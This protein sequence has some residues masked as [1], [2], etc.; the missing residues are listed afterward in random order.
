MIGEVVSLRRAHEGFSAST[1][2]H[3]GQ[4]LHSIRSSEL[5]GRTSRT[6]KSYSVSGSGQRF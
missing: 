5:M 3:S 2:K 4:T 1:R 6:S